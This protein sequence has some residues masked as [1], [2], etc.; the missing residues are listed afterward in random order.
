MGAEL[1]KDSQ[2]IEH[3]VL[4]NGYSRKMKNDEDFECV[5]ILGLGNND[6]V[7]Q[8]KKVISKIDNRAYVMKEI[9][10]DY[11]KEEEKIFYPKDRENLIEILNILKKDECPNIVKNYK[12]YTEGK[13]LYI[14]DEFIN[15]E[16]L[17]NYMKTLKMLKNDF[18]QKIDEENLWNIFLQCANGL[19]YLHSKNIIHGNIRLENIYITN[20]NCVKL[21]NFT[22]AFIIKENK[23]PQMPNPFYRKKKRG[24]LYR[25]P[26]IING[27]SLDL[28]KKEDIYSLGVVFHKLC[29]YEFPSSEEYETN[30]DK[31]SF[32]Y[33]KTMIEIIDKMLSKEEENRPDADKL[34]KLI[35]N[36]YL[37]IVNNNTS[38]EAVLRC[39]SS[40]EITS[41]DMIEEKENFKD[42]Q[43][44]PFCFNYI[45]CLENF[46]AKGDKNNCGLYLNY[47]RNLINKIND[48]I[49][50][51]QEINPL[52]VI[53][54]LLEELN[55]ETNIDNSNTPSFKNQPFDFFQS[56][57]EAMKVCEKKYNSKFIKNFCGFLK[58]RRN[59]ENCKE[60]G[61]YNY[62]VIPYLEFQ[63]DRCLAFKKDQKDGNRLENWFD[64]QFSSIIGS[65]NRLLSKDYK[66]EKCQQSKIREFKQ[67]QTASEFQK[68]LIIGINRGE[69]YINDSKINYDLKLNL[70]I[71]ARKPNS[72]VCGLNKFVYEL[73]GIVKRINNEKKEYFISL[74]LDPSD[75]KTWILSNK[76]S[77]KPIDNPIE[78]KEGEVILLFYQKSD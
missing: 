73:I 2:G 71:N 6:G 24:N 31:N 10:I 59:C 44:F 58:T 12:Y 35:L 40:Y 52:L 32:G 43:K 15:N 70:E 9:K 39:L 62:I 47:I 78:H 4:M 45:K 55:K 22:R 37:K 64:N 7:I 38:I 56:K 18:N 8:T 53:D 16:D 33:P 3:L 41:K 57:E 13:Y 17:L 46:R 5:S 69:G 28:E 61:K 68:Y 50:I 23:N 76:K 19:K 36:E 75:R 60:N 54:T 48:L 51:D 11:E 26:T 74:N 66:C 21:G 27:A 25:S 42:E 77:I 72:Q 65:K 67:I 63:L 29:F 34:Y 20:D 14:L 1:T 30:I 49:N